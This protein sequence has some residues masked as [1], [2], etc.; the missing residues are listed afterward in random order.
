V[1]GG[2]LLVFFPVVN[3]STTVMKLGV[4]T[5]TI[6]LA[7]IAFIASCVQPVAPALVGKMAQ[8]ERVSL[9]QLLMQLTL[10]F[11][12]NLLNLMVL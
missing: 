12:V 5:P 8:L 6:A 1:L 7:M 9:L 4:L 11:C 2:A 10:C 3:A